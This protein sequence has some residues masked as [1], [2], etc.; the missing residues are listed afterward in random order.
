MARL[1]TSALPF[2]RARRDLPVRVGV[3]LGYLRQ[4]F[5]EF[6]RN[7]AMGM[8]GM[9]AFFG[10]LSLIPLVLLLLAITGSILAGV[11]APKDIERIFHS[12]IPGLTRHQ[13]L[14]TYWDP[15]RHSSVA[16]TILGVV[17]LLLGTL[18]LHDSVDWAVNRIWHSTKTRPFWIGKLRGLAVVVWA[19]GFGLFSLWLAWLWSVLLGTAHAPT[20]LEAVWIALVPSLILDGAIFTLLYKLTPT[21]HV[22]LLPALVSGIL[23]AVLWEISKIGFGWWAV[24]V[25]TYN[26]VYGPLA[27]SVIVMLWLWISAMIFLFGAQLS[28]V[29]QS[30]RSLSAERSS[31]SM[32]I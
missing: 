1:T 22:D 20:P 14:S 26:R 10:F 24:Q 11:V 27:A 13:F 16:T 12:I 32:M 18:G 29:M 25:A 19:V 15:V 7:N 9:I 4:T 28:A 17:S 2:P 23:G 30:R 31:W 5:I 21:S 3:P 6:S 8:A